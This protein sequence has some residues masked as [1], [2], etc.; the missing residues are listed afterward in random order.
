MKL[1]WWFCASCGSGLSVAAA[2]HHDIAGAVVG[3]VW[4][5]ASVY[6]L[7]RL[8]ADLGARELLLSCIVEPYATTSA[9]VLKRRTTKEI[10]E[11]WAL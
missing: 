5:S 2:W 1:L 6:A 3:G 7:C 11:E 8:Y 9:A 10:L 4:T